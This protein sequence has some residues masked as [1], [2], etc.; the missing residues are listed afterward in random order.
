TKWA[1]GLFNAAVT[2]LARNANETN[3]RRDFINSPDAPRWIE[4]AQ[5][6]YNP[7]PNDGFYIHNN[8]TGGPQSDRWASDR[9]RTFIES[10]DVRSLPD[11][12]TFD[13]NGAFGVQ[14]RL[15]LRKASPQPGGAAGSV[16][17]NP[18]HQ[19]GLTLDIETPSKDSENPF[20]ATVKVNGD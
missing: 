17:P 4:L 11:D 5:T 15:E 10:T 14:P 7:T 13:G 2:G 20:F 3:V 8:T 16:S 6:Q 18:D 1:I 19:A 9:A 12:G